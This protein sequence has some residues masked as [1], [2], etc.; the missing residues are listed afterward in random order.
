MATEEAVKARGVAAPYGGV[1]R[2][3]N[4]DYNRLYYDPDITYT[5]WP[6]ED[7]LGNL[8]R[9]ANPAA[10]PYNPYTPVTGTMNLT[11]T[12]TYTT[13]YCAGGGGSFTVSYFPARYNLW[14]DTNAN[15]IVDAADLHKLV[16]IEPSTPLYVGGL[17]RRDCAAAP[18]CTYTEEIQNF[19]NWFSYYRKREY[20]AKAG[21][22]QVI[23]GA[24]NSRMGLVT[25][26]N[27]AFVNTAVGSMNDDPRSGA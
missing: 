8:Y 12:A 6:G 19:A 25:L 2:A 17:N 23:A 15:G 20:V 7:S 16:E 4:K 21:Y 3:W 9:D 22:G 26:H 1:W 10:A 14:D 27:N 11:A 13:D 5:P 24:S 18:T